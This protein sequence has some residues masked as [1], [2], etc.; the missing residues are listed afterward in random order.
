MDEFLHKQS[1]A[2]EMEIQEAGIQLES[3]VGEQPHHLSTEC[4]RKGR[5]AR[6]CQPHHNIF[7]MVGTKPQKRGHRRVKLPERM[8]EWGAIEY[9]D[10][11][12]FAHRHQ[13]GIRFRG[14]IDH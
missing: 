13:G 2:G 7:I 4:W 8:R 6:S 14:A 5:F 3:S 12:A 10:P 1:C 11:R 9:G